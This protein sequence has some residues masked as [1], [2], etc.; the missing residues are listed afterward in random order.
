MPVLRANKVSASDLSSRVLSIALASDVAPEPGLLADEYGAAKS[1]G[2]FIKRVL[3]KHQEDVQA[4]CR[5]NI[6]KKERSRV[7]KRQGVVANT[8]RS[9]C[10]VILTCVRPPGGEVT[11]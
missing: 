4:V 5:T 8:D 7:P 3:L 1:A 9:T 10:R 2:I 11:G 6:G